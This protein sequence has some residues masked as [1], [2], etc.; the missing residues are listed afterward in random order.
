MSS[1]R[2]TV[3]VALAGNLLIAVTKFV[4]AL[5]TGSSAMF[6]EAFHSLVDTSNEGLLLYGQ[7]RAARPPDDEHPMG[8]GRELY[9]WSFIVAVLIFALGAGLA[10]YEGVQHVISPEPTTDPVVNYIVLGLA[11]LFESTSWVVAF[12]NFIKAKGDLGFW[13]AILRSKDPPAFI[14]LFEDSAAIIGILIAAVGIVASVYF[15]MPVLDGIASI[16]I[17]ALLAATAIFLARESKSLLIG[18]PASPEIARKIREIAEHDPAVQDVISLW[19]V[20][21]APDQIIAM[22]ELDFRDLSADEVEKAIARIQ[23][24]VNAET[25][26]IVATFIRPPAPTG[27]QGIAAEARES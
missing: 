8:H 24:R 10:I 16:G 23:K 7:R 9:F 12:R 13:A 22:L 26:F 27:F 17:G 11:F 20:H 19:T 3:Y 4:A 6:S 14:V 18:E 5:W 1:T 21:L 15:E 2:M 25:P